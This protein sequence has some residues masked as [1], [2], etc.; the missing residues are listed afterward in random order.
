[1]YKVKKIGFIEIHNNKLEYS[2]FD[3]KIR[4]TDL[5]LIIKFN[6][7]DIDY[8]RVILNQYL[9]SGYGYSP[10]ICI[11]INSNKKKIYRISKNSLNLILK[12]Y[13][14]NTNIIEIEYPNDD[15]GINAYETNKI[16]VPYC[17]SY[18]R[19][20]SYYLNKIYKQLK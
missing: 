14:E 13:V 11:T 12:R 5:K 20:D 3:I 17:I 18:Y 1:M 6:K 9:L 19:P 16:L 10:V 7:Y 8:V 15:Y 2:I 4:F